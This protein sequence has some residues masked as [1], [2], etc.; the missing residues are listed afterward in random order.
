M[1]PE[2]HRRMRISAGW[3]A[4]LLLAAC[5]APRP[6]VPPPAPVQP[7]PTPLPWTAAIG[8]LQNL[9]NNQTCT[10]TLVEQNL[11][12]TAAHCLS[13]NRPDLAGREFVFLPNEGAAPNFPPLPIRG[14]QAVGATVQQGVIRSS[15]ATG[16][17]ALL[18]IEP[19][20][21]DLHPIAV[22][23]LTWEQIQGRLAAGDHFFSGGY[24]A[25]GMQM[26]TQHRNCKPI[27]AAELGEFLNDG[28]IATDCTVR[29]RDSGGPMVLVDTVGQPHLF[30]VISG[31]A[32]P[33][34]DHPF[35]VGVDSSRFLPFL[36][37]LPLSE[38]DG[39]VVTTPA[40]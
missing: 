11:I 17:W 40:G 32:R 1:K 8:A 33:N 7:A 37:G 15:Q 2:L 21:A 3:L 10:A 6:S 18:R 29:L 12:L 19:A 28:L 23:S 25:P 4:L 20:P 22:N 26:L 30:A 24:G 31:I 39:I 34:S 5:A 36:K 13:D 16:D 27:D 9:V 38:G 14:I 35:G